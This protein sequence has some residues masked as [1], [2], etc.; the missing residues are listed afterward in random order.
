MR[1]RRQSEPLEDC[2]LANARGFF[3]ALAHQGPLGD[4]I[5]NQAEA[6]IH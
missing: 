4:L 5:A 1:H 2:A 3:G 6:N